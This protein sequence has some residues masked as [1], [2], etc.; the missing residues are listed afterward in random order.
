MNTIKKNTDFKKVYNN[1]NSKATSLLVLYNMKNDYDYSRLGVSVS[2]KV[3]KAV[4]R[5]K[6]KRRLKEIY[7]LNEYTIKSGYDIIII[8]RVKANNATYNDLEKSFMYLL[9]KTNLLKKR[10]EE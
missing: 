4:V 5:N 1:K 3:G 2:K 7:R 6:I 10:E 8:V 9:K